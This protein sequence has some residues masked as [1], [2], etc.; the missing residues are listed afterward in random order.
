MN[1]DE[2]TAQDFIKKLEE[3]VKRK[4]GGGDFPCPL[5]TNNEWEVPPG[6]TISTLQSELP[7]L[8]LGGPSIPSIPIIC[9]N[10][11]FLAQIALGPLGMFPKGEKAMLGAQ[12]EHAN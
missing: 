2:A 4:R 10:C 8:S 5:C 9:K 1:W 7:N 6:F 12:S 3:A 11:G